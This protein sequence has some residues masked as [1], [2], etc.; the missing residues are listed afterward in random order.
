M[1]AV[2]SG[3]EFHSWFDLVP[4]FHGLQEW[5]TH[6]LPLSF[7]WK[8]PVAYIVHVPLAVVAVIIVVTLARKARRRFVAKAD[9]TLTPVVGREFPLAEANEAH[10]A[11]LAPGAAGKIVLV[12]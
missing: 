12:P 3:G 10:R 7:I 5:T 4:G 6:N 11:V 1:L 8:Q 2:A 9:G